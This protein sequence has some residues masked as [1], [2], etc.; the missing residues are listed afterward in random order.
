MG[1]SCARFSGAVS[2]GASGIPLGAVRKGASGD[3]FQRA[4]FQLHFMNAK[5]GRDRPPFSEHFMT[6]NYFV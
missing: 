1:V 2:K 4:P 6:I 3:Y 5:G